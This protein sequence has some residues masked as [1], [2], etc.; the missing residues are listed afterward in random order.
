MLP[1][2]PFRLLPCLLI[3]ITGC[4]PAPEDPAALERW[5]DPTVFQV[6]RE[7]PHATF[8]PFSERSEA[9]AGNRDSSPF[10]LSVNGP[11][12]FQWVRSPKEAAPDFHHPEFQDGGWSEI[13]VPS[14]WEMEGHGIPLYLEAGILP[15]PP[16][17]VDPSYNPVGSY[18]RW[19]ELPPEWEGLQV[20][21]HFGSVGSAVAVWVNG[22]EVG[23]SQGSKVPAEFDVTA[24]LQPGQNLVAARVWRWSDG[25]YL[26]D[27]DFWRLTGMERDVYLYARPALH[28][29]DLFVRAGLEEDYR[30]G[31]LSLD[32]ALRNGGEVL[33]FAEVDIELL[34]PLGAA[35]SAMSATLSVDPGASESITLVDTVP[36]PARWSA[37][38]PSLYTLLLEG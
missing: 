16:G 7:A 34:D 2:R 24:H 31:T 21:L 5:Q 3:L 36:S 13:P 8:V 10:V 17:S 15:G 33:G 30:D 29:S 37:E 14:N 22:Q 38:T 27:V 1:G 26:E 6:N 9:L 35:V 32:V 20:A 4:S 23:Y 25:S 19:F 28:L 18:R 12:R 11:W